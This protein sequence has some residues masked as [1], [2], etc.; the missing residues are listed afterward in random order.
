[1]ERE[2]L[3]TSLVVQWL[4]L[5]TPNAGG[6]GLIPVQGNRFPMLQL[7]ILDSTTKF[8]DSTAEIKTGSGQINILK[9]RERTL[10]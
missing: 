1:M 6:L 10:D 2:D 7:K 5:C 8:E 4:R 3:E 9:K